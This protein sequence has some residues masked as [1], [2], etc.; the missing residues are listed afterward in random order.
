MQIPDEN[1]FRLVGLKDI[2][3]SENHALE[4]DYAVFVLDRPV[5]QNMAVPL[6]LV[7]DLTPS[8]RVALVGHPL[9]ASMYIDSDDDAAEPIII[10]RKGR[11]SSLLLLGTDSYHGNSGSP[12]FSVRTGNVAGILISGADDFTIDPALGDQCAIT[13]STESLSNSVE[14]ALSINRIMG[15][16]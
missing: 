12:I 14:T 7:D 13:A 3:I 11:N 2:G 8:D 6:K 16:D 5:P 1:V 10:A 15:E 4:D 9:G